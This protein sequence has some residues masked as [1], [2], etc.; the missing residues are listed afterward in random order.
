MILQANT[1][2]KSAY[3]YYISSLWS[4]NEVSRTDTEHVF[5]HATLPGKLTA[6]DRTWK[7]V[8]GMYYLYYFLLFGNPYVQVL[9]GVCVLFCGT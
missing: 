5:L 1:L 3:A 9:M 8:V 4:T 6:K 7:L 2:N